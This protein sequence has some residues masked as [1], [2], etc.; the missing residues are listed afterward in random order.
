MSETK[1]NDS[2]LDKIRG[3]QINDGESPVPDLTGRTLGDFYA[4]QKMNVTSGEAD[5]YR[6]SGIGVHAGKHYVLKYYRR[7]N[8]VKP[9]VIEKL[10]R[11]TNPCVAPVVSFGVYEKH[12][13][14]VLPYYEMPALSDVLARGERFSEEELRNF[15]IP[16][17]IEG[18]KA[19]HDAGI[20]HKDLKPGNLIPD[21]TGEHIV[22]IDFGISSDAGKNTILVTRTGMTPAYA[23]PEAVQGIFHRE[24]DYYALGITIFELFTGFTPFLNAGLSPEEI[25]ILAAVNKIS[26]PADFPPRLKDLVLGLTFK[27]LSHRNEKDN[28]NRRWGYDEVRRW[29]NG[30]DVPV[31]GKNGSP[32]PQLKFLPYSL[33]GVKH[34]TLE[35]LVKAMLKD[36][37]AGIREAGRGILTHHFGLFA[38]DLEKICREAEDSLQKNTDTV[39]SHQIFYRLMY[40]LLPELKSIF[41]GGQEFG[42]LRE[43]GDAAIAAATSGDTGFASDLRLLQSS[44][45]D[46]YARTILKSDKARDLLQKASLQISRQQCSDLQTTWILGSALS[47]K[48][49][50]RIGDKSFNNPAELLGYLKKLESEEGFSGYIKYIEDHRSD[51]EFLA[52]AI[53]EAKSRE[54]LRLVLEDLNRAVFGQDEFQFR[55]AKSFDDYVG[56][57]LREKQTYRLRQL[58]STY[59]AALKE[60][61]DK[62]WRSNSYNNLKKTVS[63][64]VMLG[65]RIFPSVQDLKAYLEKQFQENQDTLEFFRNF[66]SYHNKALTELEK[67]PALAQIIGRFRSCAICDTDKQAGITVNDVKYPTWKPMLAKVGA[68]VKFGSYPQN[69][70]SAK[71]PIEWLVLEVNGN[72]ALLVSRY[73]LDCQ[74]YH[75]GCVSMTWERSDLRKW[76]N[77]DF[78]KAAFSAEEQCRIKLSEVVNDDNRAYSTRGGN[79]TQDWV[80]CLS[81]AEAE[82]YFKNN[83]ERKCQ[84]TAHARS[85]LAS[86]KKKN[87]CWWLRSPGEDQCCAAR[88]NGYGILDSE[89]D[90]IDVNCYVVRPAIR[91]I[92]K[93]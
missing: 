89:G 19:L 21:D 5:I 58:L 90:R 83:S 78:L 36:P 43:L 92:W 29:L 39:S 70:G 6:C 71:E 17:V 82:R 88:V 8:A 51:L 40:R 47:D 62:V 63:G 48:R 46:F 2:F 61:S 3:T 67:K 10:K 32:E 22:L 73:A 72:K 57:L 11:I 93:I 76:L 74:S 9:D 60:V 56:R 14:A 16:S 44:F 38:P 85:S 4:E 28:P 33:G 15:I 25:S 31:P 52:A 91:L 79:N 66:V 55:N 81:L 65:E 87:G 75:H 41:C 37:A 84:L 18:L 27:D 23:A 86:V 50:I 80:F 45:L 49:N 20:L 26:F 35:S 64:F 53:P 7:E 77:N 68:Y 34:Q 59:D 12:Q 69:N 24:T 1:I 30:E 42:N 13:Y 54:A